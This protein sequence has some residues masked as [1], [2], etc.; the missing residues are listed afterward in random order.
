MELFAG[1]RTVQIIK[2]DPRCVFCGETAQSERC[3]NRKVLV[4]AF[5]VAERF[6]RKPFTFASGFSVIM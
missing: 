2:Q 6:T 5:G 4:E 3:E 1:D